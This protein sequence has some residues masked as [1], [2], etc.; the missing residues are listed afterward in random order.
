MWCK[1]FSLIIFYVLKAVV[2]KTENKYNSFEFDADAVF[3]VKQVFTEEAPRPLGPYSQGIQFGRTI[4]TSGL[5]GMDNNTLKLAPG[6][7]G[8]EAKQ[9]MRNLR[10]ILDEINCNWANVLKT[11]M[12]LTDMNDFHMANEKYKEHIREPFPARTTVGVS[13]L[14]LGAKVAIDAIIGYG[15]SWSAAGAVSPDYTTEKDLM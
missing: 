11:T 13:A 12:Y 4:Y 9:I 6:G 1:L 5:L 8:A 15:D 3:Q 7:A 2:C 14:P 10:A